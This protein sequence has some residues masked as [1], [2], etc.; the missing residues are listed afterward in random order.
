[1]V[2][3]LDVIPAMKA[4]TMRR[5]FQVWCGAGVV[6]VPW[7][8]FSNDGIGLLI[9]WASVVSFFLYATLTPNCSWFG[10]V[11]TRFQTN[12]PEVW[13]TIDDGPHP[14]DTPHILGLLAEHN[15]RAT[16]FVI[17]SQ[18][19][20]Y[21]E[22]MRDI[23]KQGHT[24]GNHTQT[25]PVASFWM[26]LPAR[27]RREVE[28]CAASIFRA[29]GSGVP[30]LFRAPVGMANYWVGS[31][32]QQSGMRLIGWSARGFDAVKTDPEE[33]VN[34]IWRDVAPGAILLLHEGHHQGGK[35]RLV[36]PRAI[37]LLL[38][39]LSMA[40]YRCVIPSVR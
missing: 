7:L 34:L 29:T 1:M 17:G 35:D 20:K 16:F 2:D 30:T 28:G 15:A 10:P 21:P 24:L 18:A 33:I 36:N 6:V 27:I 8:V 12:Q 3:L 22:L 38:E 11:L 5:A 39:R 25:H 23:L 14:V 13:L 32:L 19:A 9:A 40:G 37:A 31:V 4:L 26:A